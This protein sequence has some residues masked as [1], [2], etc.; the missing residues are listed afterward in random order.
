MPV[1]LLVTKFFH[2]AIDVV[3]IGRTTLWRDRRSFDEGL[4]D[5]FPR[6]IFQQR[7][8]GSGCSRLGSFLSKRLFAYSD[9]FL[10][11][12]RIAGMLARVLGFRF[13]HGRWPTVG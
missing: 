9:G 5:D 13:V 3:K 7:E 11:E 6:F 1:P 12:S 10:V 2:L 4:N 8:N